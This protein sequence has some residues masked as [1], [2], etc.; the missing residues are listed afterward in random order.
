MLSAENCMVVFLTSFLQH[1]LEIFVIT[2]VL[3][4]SKISGYFSFPMFC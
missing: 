4:V 2:C 3:S 1:N